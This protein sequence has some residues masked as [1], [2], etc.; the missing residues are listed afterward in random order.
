MTD[1][2]PPVRDPTQWPRLSLGSAE[3]FVA[4]LTERVGFT[5]LDCA[6]RR[7]VGA[8]RVRWST[9]VRQSK[10]ALSSHGVMRC[11]GRFRWFATGEAVWQSVSA[12]PC[13]TVADVSDQYTMGCHSIGLGWHTQAGT[14]S[15]THALWH[16]V[17]QAL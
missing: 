17:P 12:I 9:I 16:A 7:R 10:A 3:V 5:V 8:V 4:A 1:H 2:E 6:T 14:H 13:D 15:A 11:I